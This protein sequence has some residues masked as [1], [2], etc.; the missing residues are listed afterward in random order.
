VNSSSSLVLRSS[1]C[2]KVPSSI[3]TSTYTTCVEVPTRP[4]PQE[5]DGGPKAIL[6]HDKFVT[7]TLRS[8]MYG[9]Y[10]GCCCLHM[11]PSR[12]KREPSDGHQKN[13]P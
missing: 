4:R 9:Y 10:V 12:S 5:Q 7:L 3:K 2:G 1:N 8:C 6:L 13:L 11:I